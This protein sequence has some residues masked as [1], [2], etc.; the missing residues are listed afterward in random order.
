MTNGF[1]QKSLCVVSEAEVYTKS[2]PGAVAT[3]SVRVLNRL[4]E[5]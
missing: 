4:F 1:A 3:G 2:E 5:H